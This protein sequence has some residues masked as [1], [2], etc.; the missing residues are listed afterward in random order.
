MADFWT[1]RLPYA[2]PP[3]SLNGRQHWATKARITR[4]LI[5]AVTVGSWQQKMMPCESIHVE[6]IYVPR[7][8]RARDRD[9]LVATLKPCID[10]LVRAGLVPDDTPEFVS[11]APPIIAPPDSKDPHLRLEIT[12]GKRG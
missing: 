8:R 5:H 3:L 2:T 4:E 11:W 12:R 10:A 6:L 7:D 1:I 9:N